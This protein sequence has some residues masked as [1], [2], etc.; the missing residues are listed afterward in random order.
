MGGV[1]GL[2]DGLL[3]DGLLLIRLIIRHGMIYE[4]PS[5]TCLGRSVHV[6]PGVA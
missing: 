6:V 5:E 2:L 4:T 3:L 1:L